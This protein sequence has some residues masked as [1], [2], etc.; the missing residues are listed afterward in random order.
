MTTE[1]GIQTI[2][3]LISIMLA[4]TFHEAA[5][6][7]VARLFGDHTASRLGRVTLNPF[8]HIDLIGTILLP[9]FMLLSH[10]PFLFGYAK[11]VPVQFEYLHPKR[12]GMILV[13][14][15]GPGMN[16][17]LAWISGL[18]LHINMGSDTLGNEILINS[19]RFNVVLAIFNMMPLP[20]LDGGRVAVGILPKPLSRALASLEPFGFIILLALIILPSMLFQPMGINFNPLREILVPSIQWLTQW[21]LFLS[22]H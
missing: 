4:I 19:I 22:G 15:A 3:L 13:A 12:L 18:L 1:T 6:G 14:A 5:H 9:G 8:K 17:L 16:L 11:P 2:A 21:V 10:A 7:F 20:P